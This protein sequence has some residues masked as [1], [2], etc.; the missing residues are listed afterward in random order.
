MK[1]IPKILMHVLKDYFK[2]FIFLIIPFITNSIL[3]QEKLK[4]VDISL[5][6]SIKYVQFDVHTVSNIRYSPANLFDAKSNTCWV[7][8]TN[9]SEMSSLYL[10][11]P[12]S[13]NIVMNI[14]SGYGKSSNLYL[15]NARPKKINL[16]LY[17]AVNP[18]GYVSENG[19]LYKAVKFPHTQVIQLTDNF[20]VQS[21]PFDFSK[22]D[23]NEF[24]NKASHSFDSAFKIPKANS[25]LILELE[26]IETFPGTNYDDV[27]I[28]ELFFNDRFVSFHPVFPNQIS[29]VY[30]NHTENILL[31]DNEIKQG[32]IAYKDTSSILQIIEVSKNKKYAILIAMPAEIQ[33]RA[34]TTYLLVDLLNRKM[35][36]PQLEKYTGNYLSGNEIYFDFQTDNMMNLVYLA[37][38]GEYLKLE[39][40]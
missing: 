32:I 20:G 37:K 19:F 21:I 17:V 2:L 28:S 30:L 27:C 13:D 22:K 16:N 24:R 25:C 38:N 8:G 40:K 31:L 14:F 11:L 4:W 39:L 5:T 1:C 29:R 7:S 12:D 23:L 33:G 6:D 35:I 26:I 36:N 18:E 15:Q 3:A 9:Q 10:K 34:E